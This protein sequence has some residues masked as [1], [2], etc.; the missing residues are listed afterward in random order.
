MLVL[1]LLDNSDLEYNFSQDVDFI[2]IIFYM[3]L[4]HRVPDS[5][6]GFTRTTFELRY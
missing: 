6:S 2:K 4:P 1:E 3:T 5:S